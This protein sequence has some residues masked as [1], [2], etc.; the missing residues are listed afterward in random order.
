MRMLHA[1]RS[2][3]FAGAKRRMR[4]LHAARSDAFAGAKRHTGDEYAAAC[5]AHRKPYTA[6]AQLEATD[7]V[8]R[9]VLA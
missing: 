9:A 5:A 6:R 3:A 2:D 1:A 4:M 7:A 8:Y